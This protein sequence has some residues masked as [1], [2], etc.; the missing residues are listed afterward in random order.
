[1]HSLQTSFSKHVTSSAS[2]AVDVVDI[3]LGVVDEDAVDVELGLVDEEAVVV[4]L[5]LVDVEVV[6]DGPKVGDAMV[7]AVGE[8]AGVRISVPS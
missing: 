3:E 4:E 8:G 2:Q 7:R 1:M 6:D 5:G